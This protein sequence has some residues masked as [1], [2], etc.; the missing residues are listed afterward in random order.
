VA[1]EHENLL[2]K[3]IMDKTISK[4]EVFNFPLKIAILYPQT[5]EIGKQ[6]LNEF[7][8]IIRNEKGNSYLIIFGYLDNYR[9]FWN[10]HSIN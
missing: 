2:E 6:M 1:L 4:L 5:R 3:E 7:R 9:V 8:S 10:F